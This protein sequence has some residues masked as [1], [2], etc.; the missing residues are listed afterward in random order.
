MKTIKRALFIGAIT[1]VVM[2]AGCK[3]E[4]SKEAVEVTSVNE[5]EAVEEVSEFV[6]A[7]IADMEQSIA[8]GETAP[9][10]EAPEMTVA[11]TEEVPVIISKES[12][13]GSWLLSGALIEFYADGHFE[14]YMSD[15]KDPLRCQ[16]G[17]YAHENYDGNKNGENDS[18]LF[19]LNIE[20]I[21]VDDLYT[22]TDNR[23]LPMVLVEELEAG[24]VYTIM[25]MNTSGTNAFTRVEGS[26][27]EPLSL[28]GK[29]EVSMETLE[30]AFNE[31]Q[32][33]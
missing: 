30:A 33:E 11:T 12:L 23:I 7:L 26:L 4:P 1:M 8:N 17:T 3:N 15:V 13:V 28:E 18:S 21:I 25:N 16:I 29:E 14:Y 6:D 10:T 19:I 22:I 5:V 24:E 9:T 31:A 32:S 20:K 2:I 27:A